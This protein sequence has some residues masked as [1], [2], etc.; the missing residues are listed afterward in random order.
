V[1]PE[2]GELLLRGL[3]RGYPH[4]DEAGA[5]PLDGERDGLAVHPRR[6]GDEHAYHGASVPAS[7][8]PAAPSGKKDRYAQDLAAKGASRADPPPSRLTSDELPRTPSRN[9]LKSLDG[10]KTKALEAYEAGQRGSFR[11]GMLA[12]SALEAPL[13]DFLDS[14]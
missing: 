9:C 12:I 14:F 3:R 8:A 11:Y 5:A 4:L 7:G 2:G 10:R 1:R 13:S 6:E